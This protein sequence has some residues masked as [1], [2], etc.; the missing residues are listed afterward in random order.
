MWARLHSSPLG[1]LAAGFY[2]KTFLWPSWRMFEPAIR[3]ATGFG[4]AQSG[5]D[6]RSVEHRHSSCDVLVIG[7]G[8]AG[9]ITARALQGTG[10]TVVVADEQAMLGG[11]L[12]WER[13]SFDGRSA[14]NFRQEMLAGL[15]SDAAFTLLPSTMATAAY[16]NNVFTL[17][18]S[19]H[20][21]GG[22]RG[23]RHWTLRA[24]NVVLA[25]GMIDRPLLFDG[26][27][28]PGVMLS[29]SVRRLMG[30][31]AVAPARQLAIYTNNDSAYLTA[32]EARRAGMTVAGIIDT[33]AANVAR[34]TPMRPQGWKFRCHFDSQIETTSGYRRLTGVLVRTS[35]GAAH[36]SPPATGW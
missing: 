25:T 16:E 13:A 8:P 9:L 3:R 36:R 29:S 12:L 2:Y 20:D 14:Q 7:A 34:R 15:Q 27:D 35:G 31:F 4:R 21:A 10:L 28:R 33:R 26:N 18:Q 22:I 5:V 19:L 17:V 1:I 23:E 24:Q 6:R 32:I 11:S 30:E